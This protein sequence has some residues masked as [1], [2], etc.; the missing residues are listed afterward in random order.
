M[1][2]KKNVVV[3][4]A[5]A[6]ADLPGGE[7]IND[8]VNWKFATSADELRQNLPGSEILLGWNFRADELSA[9]WDSATDLAW[10][11]WCGAGV[12]AVL[13]PALRRSDVILT[14]A[15]GVFD[16]P[17]AEYVLGL[18]I[19]LAKRFPQTFLAKSTRTW[20]YGLNETISGR[21]VLVVGTGSIGRAIAQLLRNVGMQVSGVG[22][23]RRSGDADFDNVYGIDE[24]DG[25]LGDFDFVISVVPLTDSTRDLFSEK[26]FQVMRSSARFINVGRGASVDESALADALQQ[27]D[28]AAAAL[29]VF[30]TE[31]LPD[32]SPLWS[33]DNLIIS[34]HMSGDYVGHHR[35][36]V[37]QFI[38]NLRC[39]QSG[40]SM[41][42][43][44]DK[45]A[46]FVASPR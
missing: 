23:N 5:K 36:L 29:D 35:T 12:D 37:E 39:Y 13:F 30:K 7:R 40:E 41:R 19:A 14:N 43:I 44:V 10:I 42:N 2:G 16:R 17:I 25:V 24:L 1:N 4:G 45:A 33:V 32:D 22:R 31:P 26:Q 18:V 27:G 6:V 46:G 3:L 21:P 28:I 11:H 8:E 34:P 38:H 20:A 9:A 15:R